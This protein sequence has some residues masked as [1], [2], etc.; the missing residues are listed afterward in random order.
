[1]AESI[2]IR[3]QR[4]LSGGA[5]AA[6]GTL[7]RASST[8]LM[9]EAIREVER[10]IEDIRA[11]HEEATTRRVHAGRQQQLIRERLATLREQ[12]VFVIG[13]GRED[14]AEATIA[15][16]LDFERELERQKRFEAEAKDEIVRLDDC[17]SQLKVR[18]GQMEKEL[19]N[20]QAAQR[21]ASIAGACPPSAD[22]RAER[23]AS[24]AEAAFE[25]AMAAAG[26]ATVG[27]MD[28]AEA[29]K[30]SEIETLQRESAIAERLAAL[31]AAQ[32][33]GGTESARKRAG[34]QAKA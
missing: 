14:L 16:Q 21:E 32:T 6:V 26:G 10:A 23:K 2:F 15:R 20:F 30:L 11:K 28:A 25:R 8:S 17:L 29:A 18:K 22:M 3:V 27:L 13:K 12:A 4:V 33:Q 1:M 9:R 24:R 34:K 19:A 7:E 5:D 31:R